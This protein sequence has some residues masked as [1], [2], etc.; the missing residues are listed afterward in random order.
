[1]ENKTEGWMKLDNAKLWH[2]FREGRSLCGK[3]MAFSHDYDETENIDSPDNCKACTNKR[4]KELSNSNPASCHK[5]RGSNNTPDIISAPAKPVSPYVV[6]IK[7][8]VDKPHEDTGG[9]FTIIHMDK[10]TDKKD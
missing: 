3:W 8:R 6:E 4:S 9:G 10:I 2:Y 1:M 5:G 7:S